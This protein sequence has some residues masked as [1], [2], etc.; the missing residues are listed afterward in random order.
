MSMYDDTQYKM[1]SGAKL[2]VG[3]VIGVVALIVLAIINPMTI[4]GAGEKGVV[5]K[6]GAV[7]DNVLDAGIHWVTPIRDSVKKMDVQ[8]Q[9]M[10][11]T[12]LAYSK[13]IQTVET[14][15]ALNY[16]LKPE[17]VNNIWREVGKDYQTD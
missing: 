16:H 3:L 7:Q 9:K 14:K 6:W 1:N 4:V 2:I 15:L 12:T 13:D 5:L 11:I 17:L 10:E 8:T